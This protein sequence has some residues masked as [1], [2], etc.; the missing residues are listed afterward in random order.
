MKKQ[1]LERLEAELETARLKEEIDKKVYEIADSSDIASYAIKYA[2]YTKSQGYTNGI[3]E[4]IDIVNRIR[5][6]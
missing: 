6:E 1:I 3:L 4:A 2:H 5:E